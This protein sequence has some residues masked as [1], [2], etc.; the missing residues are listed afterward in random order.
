MPSREALAAFVAGASGRVGKKEIA[1]HFGLGPGDRVA[2]KG[3]LRD[4]AARP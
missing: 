4:L 3:A 1:R 2:L